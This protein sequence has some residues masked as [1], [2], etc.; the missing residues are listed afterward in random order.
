MVLTARLV[1]NVGR[2]YIAYYAL[3]VVNI[4]VSCF[5]TPVAISHNWH[6]VAIRIERSVF[7]FRLVRGAGHFLVDRIVFRRVD[8]I[9]SCHRAHLSI[10]VHFVQFATGQVAVRY[11]CRHH[12]HVVAANLH[13]VH[14]TRPIE[15][16]NHKRQ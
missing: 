3:I 2:V 9:P 6:R 10:R 13:R 7:E 8:Q 12:F 14:G 5:C 15:T 11:R 1:I 16:G 4:F